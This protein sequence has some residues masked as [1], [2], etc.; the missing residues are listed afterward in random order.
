MACKCWYILFSLGSKWKYFSFPWW[1]PWW[2]VIL[3]CDFLLKSL[4][5]W[6][7][8]SHYLFLIASLVSWQSEF[9]LHG[10]SPLQCAD[11]CF[12]CRIWS[13]FIT[14][15]PCVLV[16]RAL[17]PPHLGECKTWQLKFHWGSVA[18]YS[19][20]SRLMLLVAFNFLVGCECDH[21]FKGW[22]YLIHI[23]S[24]WST[25]KTLCLSLTSSK[26][27]LFLGLKLGVAAFYYR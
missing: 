22:V 13:L 1:L 2:W 10:F 26:I 4:N 5:I 27:G 24:L 18:F 15:V 19:L 6:S 11:S 17:S 14:N 7:V 16:V 8:S 9:S 25:E 3:R 12:P 20:L 21:A 23:S